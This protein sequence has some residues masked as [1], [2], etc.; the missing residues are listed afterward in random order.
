MHQSGQTK[1]ASVTTEP[2]QMSSISVDIC[3]NGGRKTCFSLTV[4]DC[5]M[6]MHVGQGCESDASLLDTRCY[7]RVKSTFVVDRVQVGSV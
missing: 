2:C 7:I 3:E 5:Y 1:I 4:D 6:A